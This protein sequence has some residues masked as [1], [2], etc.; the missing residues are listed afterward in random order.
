MKYYQTSH[1]SVTSLGQEW[2][3][4]GR[5]VRAAKALYTATGPLGQQMPMLMQLAQPF[6]IATPPVPRIQPQ[7]LHLKNART[8]LRDQAMVQNLIV[9]GERECEKRGQSGAAEV[10]ALTSK[11]GGTTLMAPKPAAE[12]RQADADMD[13]G[14]QSDGSAAA[15]TADGELG[16]SRQRRQ[17]GQ[18]THRPVFYIIVELYSSAYSHRPF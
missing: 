10:P 2:D 5:E 8:A 17:Q 6:R 7:E 11:I 13:D 1:K 18:A 15:G 14:E 9:F 3:C 12:Q 16:T 4:L